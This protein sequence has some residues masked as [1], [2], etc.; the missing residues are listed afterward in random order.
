MRSN[1]FYSEWGRGQTLLVS[2]VATAVGAVASAAV[3]WSLVDSLTTQPDVSSISP[4][5]IVRDIAASEVKKPV[6]DQPTA[7]TALRP[8]GTNEVATQTD[9]EHQPEVHKQESRKHNRVASR[10]REPYWRGRSV[11]ASS[12][13]HFSSW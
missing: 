10:W 2:L 12:Q 1:N 4:R 3:I 7:E 9:A 13:P 6:Q 8:K 11:R 5:A